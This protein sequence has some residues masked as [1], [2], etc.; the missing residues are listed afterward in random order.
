MYG[1]SSLGC[2]DRVLVGTLS[3]DRPLWGLR[4]EGA[5]FV[6][7]AVQNVSLIGFRDV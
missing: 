6:D 1:S 5:A 4:L 3:V 7:H 2:R